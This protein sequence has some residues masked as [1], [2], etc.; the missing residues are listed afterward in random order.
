MSDMGERFKT[1]PD[2]DEKPGEPIADCP[3]CAASTNRQK[4]TTLHA[5]DCPV[6]AAIDAE[7]AEAA[8]RHASADSRGPDPFIYLEE[9]A[10]RCG[11]EHTGLAFQ[12][13]A[14]T[15]HLVYGNCGYGWDVVRVYPMCLPSN[16]FAKA[17]TYAK[18]KATRRRI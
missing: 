8:A 14:S 1:E 18:D 15:S 6:R 4:A 12:T 13:S 17:R 7:Q 3:R 16:E 11:M 2:Y 10:C 5:T 9:L